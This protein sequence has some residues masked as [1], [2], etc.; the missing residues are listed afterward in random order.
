VVF[1]LFLVVRYDGYI[2]LFV[3]V[4]FV[5]YLFIFVYWCM[6]IDRL[7][8][9]CWYVSLSECWYVG[10]C[11]MWML[12]LNGWG[13]MMMLGFSR[14]LGLKIVL[15]CL[16]S[17]IV[18][19]EYMRGSSSLWVWLLLCLF[20]MELLCVVVR[21]VVFSM[22]LWNVWVLFGWLKGKLMWMCR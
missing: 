21:W 14:L 8:W 20:D 10:V 3:L 11:V 9:S 17:A 1:F 15:M 19:F 7:L 5:W 13:L 2:I 22:N 4:V 12:V 18:L 6:V 16:N